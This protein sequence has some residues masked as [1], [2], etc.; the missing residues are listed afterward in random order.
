LE[1]PRVSSEGRGESA[2]SE[3]TYCGGV[4]VESIAGD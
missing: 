1:A 4:E 3:T 2:A